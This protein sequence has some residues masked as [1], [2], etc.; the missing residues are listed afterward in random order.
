L[1]RLLPLRGGLLWVGS[2]SATPVSAALR[3]VPSLLRFVSVL[4][5]IVQVSVLLSQHR[6]I[7]AITTG[8]RP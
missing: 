1:L 8:G 3:P 7:L 6:A 2:P 4:V 5:L